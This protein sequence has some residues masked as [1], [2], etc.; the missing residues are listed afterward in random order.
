LSNSVK[1]R[2]DVTIVNKD[3][4]EPE[5]TVL[6]INKENLSRSPLVEIL[7]E[8][9]TKVR[10][11]LDSGSDVKLLAH[12]IY[13]KLINSGIHILTLHLQNV[14][15]VTAFGK[16]TNRVRKQAMIAFTIGTKMFESNFFISPQLVN[17]AILGCQ[18]M[19]DY[20][21]NLNF[22]RGSFTSFR[23]NEVQEHMFYQTAGTAEVGRSHRYGREATFPTPEHTGQLPVSPQL[24]A[25]SASVA[26][27][28]HCSRS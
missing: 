9:D 26:P 28:S 2:L 20:G 27:P 25:L 14:I 18:F 5:A 7:L 12:D 17:D 11:I 15:L 1:E 13:D 8:S 6:F 24:T 23:D 22:K 19:Q 10:A 4:M 3:M 16:K 21:I